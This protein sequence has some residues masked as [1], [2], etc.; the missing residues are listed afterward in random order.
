MKIFFIICLI[1]L[2]CKPRVNPKIEDPTA[3]KVKEEKWI[4][5]PTSGLYL[6]E[7]PSQTAKSIRLLPRATMLT[8]K[9]ILENEKDGIIDEQ[10]GKWLKV[11]VGNESG[12]VFDVYLSEAIFNSS[13]EKFYFYTYTAKNR[14][15][16]SKE[17]SL[18]ACGSEYQ[19]YEYSCEIDVMKYENQIPIKLTNFEKLLIVGWFDEKSLLS[20][21][22]FGDAGTSILSYES[23]DVISR[24]RKQ[25]YYDIATEMFT[26]DGIPP[27]YI[28]QRYQTCYFYIC[29]EFEISKEEKVFK[30]FKIKSKD[31]FLNKKF[32]QAFPFKN[33]TSIIVKYLEQEEV[34][35]LK[36]GVGTIYFSV[37]LQNYA[38]DVPTGKITEVKEK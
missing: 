11:E 23:I 32:I 31:D 10:K 34:F 28:N 33:F 15:L 4:V 12:W 1:L 30:I 6:R 29:Y 36:E 17:F 26:V 21:D 14:I 35:K 8:H 2:F 27:K 3:E 13:G 16:R 22:R 9:V 19:G 25:I 18:G 38:L 5:T 24:N 7:S 37:E 20:A